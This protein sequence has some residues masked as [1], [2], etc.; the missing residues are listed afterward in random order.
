LG[1]T[2]SLTH[3]LVEQHPKNERER[4]AAEQLVGGV[5][6][7]DAELGHPGSVPHRGSATTPW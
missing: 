5:V 3:V 4:V 6:L 7:G 2:A 1:V